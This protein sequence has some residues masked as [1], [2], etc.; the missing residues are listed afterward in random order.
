MNSWRTLCFYSFAG[1]FRVGGAAVSGQSTERP[2]LF[3]WSSGSTLGTG[4]TSHGNMNGREA[5]TAELARVRSLAVSSH[6]VTTC[7]PEIAAHRR[8]GLGN[9]SLECV[10]AFLFGLRLWSSDLHW[11]VLN[12]EVVSR[13]LQKERK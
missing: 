7:C 6:S 8:Q 1:T 2:E 4:W 9:L 12:L 5:F 13:R 11:L 10:A 3:Q